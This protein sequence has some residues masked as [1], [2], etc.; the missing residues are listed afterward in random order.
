MLDPSKLD[1]SDSVVLSDRRPALEKYYIEAAIAWRESATES[2]TVGLLDDEIAPLRWIWSGAG[3]RSMGAPSP[4][5]LPS[6]LSALGPNPRLSV[7]FGLG[8]A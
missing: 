8:V 1:L 4:T 7:T 2:V 5:S 6:L 3:D